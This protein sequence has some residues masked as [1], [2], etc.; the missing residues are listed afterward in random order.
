MD[1]ANLT[2]LMI[3]MSKQYFLLTTAETHSFQK[4][5]FLIRFSYVQSFFINIFYKNVFKRLKS[6]ENVFTPE[7]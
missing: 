5:T 3:S 2:L 6:F 7:T 1:Q 4:K